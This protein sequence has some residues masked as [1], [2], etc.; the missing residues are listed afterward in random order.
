M[1]NFLKIA[2]QMFSAER[3]ETI[4]RKAQIGDDIG[5]EV[6]VFG[7][8]ETFQYTGPY[9]EL[10]FKVLTGIEAV[11]APPLAPPAIVTPIPGTFTTEDGTEYRFINLNGE[12]LNADHVEW[13]DF[14]V[15]FT[16]AQQGIELRVATDPAGAT[17][18]LVNKDAEAA[19][20]VLV[21]LAS[22]QEEATAS[23]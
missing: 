22:N 3:V 2:T 8:T 12:I 11:A 1:H 9:A 10:A 14:A 4:N 13:V 17:R 16:P 5:I 23:Q 18:K 7:F 21:S 19:Y 6:K 20:E 15:Q